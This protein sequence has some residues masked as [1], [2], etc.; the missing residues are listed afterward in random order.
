MVHLVLA[1]MLAR[2]PAI[3]LQSVA[4]KPTYRVN[5][6]S[7]RRDYQLISPSRP[8]A[9]AVLLAG[10]GSGKGKLVFTSPLP[11][12]SYGLELAGRDDGERTI[13]VSVPLAGASRFAISAAGKARY[14]FSFRL[15]GG[16]EYRFTFTAPVSHRA[17]RLDP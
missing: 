12:G 14:D 10:A 8:G 17:F 6:R 16:K 3:R 15:P 1:C 13:V 9:I 4:G 11:A 7:D 5:L 2:E